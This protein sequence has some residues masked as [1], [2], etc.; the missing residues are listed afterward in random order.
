MIC[1]MIGWL[2]LSCRHWVTKAIVSSFMSV[3]SPLA[4]R[5]HLRYLAIY[6]RQYI[7]IYGEA[8]TTQFLQK[9]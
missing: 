8:Y 4:E 1:G 2:R 3:G 9:V 6:N 5:L 7:Y